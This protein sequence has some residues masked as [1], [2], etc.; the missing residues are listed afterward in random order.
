VTRAQNA[1]SV[2]QAPEGP[3]RLIDPTCQD[4][5]Y[6]TLAILASHTRGLDMKAY[7]QPRVKESA[8][9]AEQRQE[10]LFKTGAYLMQICRQ[11]KPLTTAT[12]QTAGRGGRP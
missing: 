5:L 11:P 9:L 3:G 1:S 8:L 2:L 4:P 6:H 10:R 12:A 7:Y